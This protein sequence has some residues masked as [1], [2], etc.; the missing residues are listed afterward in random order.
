MANLQISDA[1]LVQEYISGNEKALEKLIKRH[2]SKIYGFI[3]DKVHDKDLTEDLFQDTFINVIKAL[4]LDKYKEDG[5]FAS[6]V[7]RI[8][9]NVIVD[10]YRQ[11]SK[12]KYNRDTDDYSVFNFI[13]LKTLSPEDLLVNDTIADEL[14][15]LVEKLPENQKIVLKMRIYE[16]KSFKEIV[17]ISGLSMNTALGNMRYAIKNIKNMIKKHKIIISEYNIL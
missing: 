16:D 11:N 17:E 5:K 15:I 6:W 12:M 4:R 1:V 2:Q 10:Y 7:I 8:A 3:Y 9:K 14:M 13:N